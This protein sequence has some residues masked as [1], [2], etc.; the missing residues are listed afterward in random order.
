MSFRQSL[1]TLFAALA[2]AFAFMRV[3]LANLFVLVLL[4]LIVAGLTMMGG[5]RPDISP[6]AAL[7]IAP[8]GA[9]VEQRSAPDWSPLGGISQPDGTTVTDLRKAIERAAEDDRIAALSLDVSGLEGAS[10][11]NLDTLGAAIGQFRDAGKTVVAY[12]EYLS[13]SQYYLASF[14]DEVYIDPFGG[15]EFRGAQIHRNYFGNLLETLKVDLKVFH[16]GP[17]KSAGE[18]FTRSDMSPAAREMEQAIVDEVW[19]G[20]VERVAENRGLEAHAVERYASAYDEVLAAAGGDSARAA[21]EQ[22]LVDELLTGD[23]LRE[24]LIEKVGGDGNDG[25]R[26]ASLSAYLQGI[27]EPFPRG[28]VIAVI[29]AEG[30]ILPGEQPRGRIGGESTS[31]LIREAR[32]DDAVKAIVLRV[33]SGGGSAFASE[34]IRQELELAQTAGKPVVASMGGTAASGGYW[35][36]ATADEIWASPSTLTG[37]I[38]V[39]SLLVSLHESLAQLGIGADGVDTDA[40]IGQPARGKGISERYSNVVQSNLD[41]VYSRF[42]NLVA[43]GRDMSLED[44]ASVAGGRVWTGRQALERGLIDGLGDRRQAIA[45]AA[46]L[47]ELEDYDVRVLETE[48]SPQERLLLSLAD[49]FGVAPMRAPSSLRQAL[50]HFESLAALSDPRRVYAICHACGAF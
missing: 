33:D 37:S 35:I 41:H 15:V 39:V 49:N 13:Q 25:Y 2:R 23:A 8:D 17:Y 32:K 22:G 3:A 43:R 45:A 42:L 36:S 40:V 6:G 48:L 5:D 14:A 16:T 18:P 7:V 34:Q 9:I 11:P 47:A 10:I 12:G 20:F 31:A 38:G 50:L 19:Q 29:V 1:R 30:M 46:R 26:Q 21:L 24:R 27:V 28:D 44:V 4:L